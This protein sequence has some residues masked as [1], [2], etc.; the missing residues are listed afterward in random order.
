MC[1]N[2][3]NLHPTLHRFRNIADYWIN[4]VASAGSVSHSFGVN[5]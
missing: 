3:S 1:V 2:N 5:P 4:T